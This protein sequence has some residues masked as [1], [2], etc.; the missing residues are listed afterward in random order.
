MICVADIEKET[1]LLAKKGIYMVD[2]LFICVADIEEETVLLA[3][4]GIYSIWWMID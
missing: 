4:K 2:D 1:V 3:K